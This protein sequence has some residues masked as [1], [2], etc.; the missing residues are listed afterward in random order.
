VEL[1][2]ELD[3]S[4]VPVIF[5]WTEGKPLD[6]VMAGS[7]MAA[8]DFVRN[9]KQILDLLRQIQDVAPA[10]VADTVLEAT[11]AINRSVVAYTGV[12]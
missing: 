6:D 9:C 11:R 1:S 7:G 12:V 10:E 5:A 3:A 2:R 4:F 8:G